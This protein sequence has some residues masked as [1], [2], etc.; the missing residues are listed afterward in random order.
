MTTGLHDLADHA[1]V[2]DQDVCQ[3]SFRLLPLGPT[4]KVKAQSSPE[5]FAVHVAVQV[6]GIYQ[7]DGPMGLTDNI[8]LATHLADAMR[9]IGRDDVADAAE[10]WLA[11]FPP[12]VRFTELSDPEAL[13]GL[14]VSGAILSL[15]ENPR[16]NLSRLGLSAETL[17]QVDDLV[18]PDDRQRLSE[19][20]LQAT[21]V[22]C[23]LLDGLG[24]DVVA[25]YVRQAW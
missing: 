25:A 2:D 24:F 12:G 4:S 20:F 13:D 6:I 10:R 8:H 15:L 9:T 21:G 23:D 11:S 1:P 17:K 3:M 5:A 18:E 14:E 19:Q 16:R 22:L 7:S